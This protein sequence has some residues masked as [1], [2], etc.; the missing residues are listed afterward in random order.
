MLYIEQDFAVICI[1][2][3]EYKIKKYKT[4][5]WET[6]VIQ[7]IIVEKMFL[8]LYFNV[9]ISY[10]ISH[11]RLFSSEH[12][13]ISLN[14]LWRVECINVIEHNSQSFVSFLWKTYCIG[15]LKSK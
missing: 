8:K 15:R 6:N 10:Y 2:L 9:W 3:F 12:Q 13:L 1:K 7:E 14:Y 5:T 11:S 4:T